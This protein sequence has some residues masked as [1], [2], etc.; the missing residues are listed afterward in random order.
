MAAFSVSLNH[1][2]HFLWVMNV[3]QAAVKQLVALKGKKK[4]NLLQSTVFTAF[5][6][7]LFM[8]FRPAL[9]VKL[10]QL[11]NWCHIRQMLHHYKLCSN[12]QDFKYGGGLEIYQG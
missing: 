11:N 10:L 12:S 7:T 6:V 2:P 9:S 4:K 3:I 8:C 1:K 5:T